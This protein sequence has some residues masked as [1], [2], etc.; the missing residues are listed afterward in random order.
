M[1][2]SAKALITT[3]CI[4]LTLALSSI[5][6]GNDQSTLHSTYWNNDH[7][8]PH[9]TQEPAFMKRPVFDLA[10]KLAHDKALHVASSRRC[11]ISTLPSTESHRSRAHISRVRSQS[12][13]DLL[14]KVT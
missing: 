1:E 2:E 9:S 4:A 5:A 3:L 12:H 11:W 14:L 7:S 10:F 8:T 6:H 13:I